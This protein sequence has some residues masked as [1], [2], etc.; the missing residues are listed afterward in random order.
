MS[1]PQPWRSEAYLDS[2]R[3]EPGWAVETALLASY[4]ADLST[5]GAVL[6]ALAG[7][8]DERGS[9]SKADMADAVEEL[10][11]K[12]KIVIQRGR[13]AKLK[14]LPAVAG[15]LD[16]FLAEVPFD[17][18]WQS[19][20]PKLALVR[21]RHPEHGDAWRLWLGSRNV[22]TAENLDFGL[23]LDG[24]RGRDPRAAPI[25][26]VEALARRLAEVAKLPGVSTRKFAKEA[27]NVVWASP[28]GTRVVGLHLTSG[29]GDHTLPACP[30]ELDEVA[31]ISPFLGAGFIRAIGTWGSAGTRRSLLS[32]YTE[33]R[34]LGSAETSALAGFGDRLLVLDAPQPDDVPPEPIAAPDGSEEVAVELGLEAPPLLGLHAKILAARSDKKLRLWV[35]SANATERAWTGRNVEIVVELEAELAVFSGIEALLQRGR[36]VTPEELRTAVE[37]DAIEDRLDTARRQTAARW[38]GR[39]VRDGDR[40]DLVADRPPHPDDPDVALEVGMASGNPI[41]WPRGSKTLDLGQRE[42]GLQTA[43]V[44]FRLTLDGRECIWLQA[45]EVTPPFELDRDRAALARH[46]GPRAFL[47]WMRALVH[48]N[49]LAEAEERWDA[50]PKHRTAKNGDPLRTETLTLEDILSCWSRDRDAFARADRRMRSFLDPVI[51]EAKLSAPDEAV[52]LEALRDLWVTLRESLR[53]GP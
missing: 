5:I 2:L 52:H 28:A 50:G 19:W 22:T 27:A 8:D 30:I 39:L 25:A 36:L 48:G 23:A 44:Q 46:L 47:E 35:G 14:R 32:T 9:G 12:V 21:F 16:R 40:F 7:R 49:E 17:E 20:H 29:A 6:L 34:K 38:S 10:R 42:L 4:S 18:E 33:L 51:A 41:A 31:V 43:L 53:D 26:G 45:C 1:V 3:P 13:L 15:I 24:G 11:G 37:V